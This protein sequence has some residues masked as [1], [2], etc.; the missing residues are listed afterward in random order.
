MDFILE[1]LTLFVSLVALVTYMV[2][3]SGNQ[4]RCEKLGGEYVSSYYSE[5]TCFD[6][7]GKRIN[8]K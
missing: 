6:K 1:T 2:T 7:E 4:S 8:L 3:C 5:G